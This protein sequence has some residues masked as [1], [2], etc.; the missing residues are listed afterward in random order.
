MTPKEQF[1]AALLSVL[2]VAVPLLI[3]C[4]RLMLSKVELARLDVEAAK[5]ARLKAAA[6]DAVQYAQE[7]RLDE[8]QNGAW[9]A[10]VATDV[11]IDRTGVDD[12]T[13]AIAVRTAVAEAPG[14]G[15]TGKRNGVH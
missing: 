5:A 9:A 4:I 1:I 10:K 3:A 14:L 6:A 15:E 11:V 8:K 2:A 12:E 13:A 7:R